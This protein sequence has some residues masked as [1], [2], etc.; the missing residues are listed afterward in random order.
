MNQPMPI[1]RIEIDRMKLA[2][3]TALSEAVAAQDEDIQKAIE[4]ALSKE[5]L[6]NT[7]EATVLRAVKE[8]LQTE[9]ESYFKYG[10]GRKAIKELVSK[11]LRN[12]ISP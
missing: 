9:I 2:I 4:L 5:N 12:P 7:I 1:I 6:Q 11:N 8:S 3:Q 10:N